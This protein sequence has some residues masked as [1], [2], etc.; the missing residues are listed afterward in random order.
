MQGAAGILRAPRGLPARGARAVR[1]VR[2]FLIC[3]EVATGFGRTG[4]MFACEQ[5][6]V[7]PDLMCVAK[8]LTGGYLP[9]AATLTTER[10][11]EGFLGGFEEFRTFFHGHTYTGNPLACAAGARDAATSSSRS[12]RSSAC[13]RRSTLLRRAARRARRAAARGAPRSASAASWSASSSTGFPLEARIGHQVTLEARAPRRDHPP[14]RRHRRAD[15]PAVDRRRRSCAGWWRSPR[16]RSP[17]RRAP[18]AS[19]RPPEH[20]GSRQRGQRGAAGGE[21]RAPGV[22]RPI[23]SKRAR[24]ARPSMKPTGTASRRPPPP[25]RPCRRPRARAP[26]G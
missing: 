18:K 23:G 17:P 15:A 24:P 3:D 16:Q 5:E 4:T 25:T 1:R 12:T 22:E 6:G 7:T 10:I 14:A 2:L 19:P 8:G 21:A 20:C 13:S 11:Y 26:P 9:L